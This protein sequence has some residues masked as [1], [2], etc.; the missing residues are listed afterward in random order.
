MGFRVG[1]AVT[2]TR[3]NTASDPQT[4]AFWR[5]ASPSASAALKR[6][7][8]GRRPALT[9][10]CGTTRSTRATTRSFNIGSTPPDYDGFNEDLSELNVGSTGPT[11]IDFSEL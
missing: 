3:E 6:C 7:E 2:R 10:G 5:V 11:M 4:R 8:C 9:A 1:W